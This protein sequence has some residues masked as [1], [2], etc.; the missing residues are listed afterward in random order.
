MSELAGH[1]ARSK[2]ESPQRSKMTEL[3]ALQAIIEQLDVLTVLVIDLKNIGVW[4]LRLGCMVLG[5]IL[6]RYV[7]L[8]S[9]V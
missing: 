8:R 9:A 4:G 2:A 6:F 5:A 1:I 3:E 7:T